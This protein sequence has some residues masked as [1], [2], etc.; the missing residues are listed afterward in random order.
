MC[1]HRTT[2][3][4]PRILP[5]GHFLGARM[6]ADDGRCLGARP[7]HSA[8]RPCAPALAGC[9]SCFLALIAIGVSKDGGAERH[10][11]SPATSS[12][13]GSAVDHPRNLYQP[14]RQSTPQGVGS[15]FLLGAIH[16][17]GGTR[18]HIGRLVAWLIARRRV[19]DSCTGGRRVGGGCRC[20]CHIRGCGRCRNTSAES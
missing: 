17:C 1:G 10:Y 11:V 4:Q 8:T 16:G 9:R 3:R 14:S 2:I 20:G 19:Q 18:R 7:E 5:S 13:L 15:F 6:K 12:A